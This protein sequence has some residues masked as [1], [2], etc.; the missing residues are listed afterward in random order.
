MKRNIRLAL[1]TVIAAVLLAGCMNAGTYVMGQP[2]GGYGPGLWHTWGGDGCYWERLRGFSGGVNDIIANNFSG[3]GPR[4][5]QIEASDAGFTTSCLPWYLEQPP[6]PWAGPLVQPGQSFGPGDFKVGYEV[7]A[8]RYQS[9]GPLSPGGSC[10]WER[11]KGFHGTVDDIIANDLGSG[12]A[13]VDIA[14]GDFGFS[15]DG[16]QQWVKIG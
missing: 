3:P 13:V 4:Y 10:Y 12:S 7:A 9:A 8:G 6:G 1:G 2:G 5:V 15:S 16:C 14:P 11:L